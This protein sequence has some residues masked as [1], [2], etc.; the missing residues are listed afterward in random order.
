MIVKEI[1][2]EKIR[3]YDAIKERR[4]FFVFEQLNNLLSFSNSTKLSMRLSSLKTTYSYMLDYMRQ[5]V[6]DTQQATIYSNLILSLYEIVDEI[7]NELMTTE[8]Y[9]YIYNNHR[10]YKSFS[11]TDIRRY[12]TQLKQEQYKF[13]LLKDSGADNKLVIEQL[14]IIEKIQD[15]LFLIIASKFSYSNEEIDIIKELLNCK[16]YGYISSSMIISA[17]TISCL[18]SYCE[19]NIIML[20][21]TYMSSDNEEVKQRAL[22]GALILIFFHKEKTE[23]SIEIKKRV[24]LFSENS[25]FCNDVINQFLQFIRSLETEKISEIFTKEI[26]PELM[27]IAPDLQKRVGVDDISEENLV[28][29]LEKNPEWEKQFE[30]RGIAEKLKDLNELQLEGSDVLLSTFSSLKVY[31]FFNK[32][33]NWIRPF[34]IENSEIYPFLKEDEKIS[35]MLNNSVFMCSSDRYS[36]SLTISQFHNQNRDMMFGNIPSGSDID[37]MFKDDLNPKS[38]VSKNISTQYIQ[39]LYRLFKLS[40]FDIP[41]VFSNHINLLEAKVLAPVFDNDDTIRLLGEFYLNKELYIYAQNYYSILSNKNSSDALLYQKLGY[42]KQMLKDYDGAIKEYIKADSI[43]ED[44][45]TL[46]HLALCYRTKGDIDKA[47]EYYNIALRLKPDSLTLEFQMGNCLLLKERYEDALK[48]Y[49]KVDYL[50]EGSK[51]TWRPIAWCSLMLKKYEQAYSYMEKILDSTPTANDYMNAGHIYFT[52]KK[53]KEAYNH[54]IK[55]YDINSAND[56][57]FAKN[58]DEDKK[59]LLKLG[60]SEIEIALMRDIVLNNKM[61]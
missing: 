35:E 2:S 4:L 12:A 60:L 54:Y 25:Q 27:K 51:K 6:E 29:L 46:H 33:S 52:C 26:I 31:P 37:D 9:S 30:Q 42:C 5:G 11:E 55:C 10:L 61:I 41:D 17:L 53:F 24:N 1:E 22:C 19:K 7:I 20:L 56:N 57:S 15:E 47:I 32:L 21:D 18:Y 40:K 36:L 3:L 28:S 59:T 58:F 44:F 13:Q 43:S 34:T 38:G 39:D 48:H 8:K 23:L 16:E 50:T 45:W 49:Y 14:K